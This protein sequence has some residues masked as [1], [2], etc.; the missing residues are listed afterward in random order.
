MA[1]AL[2]MGAGGLGG[3]FDAA[4]VRPAAERAHW[5]EKRYSTAD[6]E[7]D[8]HLFY[9][10]GRELNV[11]RSRNG[12]ETWQKRSIPAP[13]DMVTLS[14]FRGLYTR[15]GTLLFPVGGKAYRPGLNMRALDDATWRQYMARSTDGGENWEWT[16]MVEDPTGAYTE[17]VTLLELEN[18]RVLALVRAHRPGPTGY[19]WQQWSADG[20]R[21]WS[22]PVETQIWGYP[23]H[24]LRLQD[25]R[26]L[27]TYGYRFKPAGIRAVL[28]GDGGW[29]WDLK[30]ERILQDDGG[31][32]AQGWGPEQLEKFKVRGVA[33][34]DLGYP[35]S[36]QMA[37]GAI[38]TVYYFTGT[39]G[40]THA[41]S[42]KWRLEGEL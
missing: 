15:D 1:L 8:P 21:P 24:L 42:S 23:C 17:E 28:S 10:S 31:T 14:G 32:P 19:L 4:E 25:G 30:G 36:A 6:H 16:K 34:A 5:E 12:G 29:S 3:H 13:D 18:D 39:D 38:V 26:I 33:G 27:C 9:L 11:G 2:L 20:G 35:F 40:I 22:E 7:N 37:D 41:A